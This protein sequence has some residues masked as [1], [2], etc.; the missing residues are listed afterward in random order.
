MLRIDVICHPMHF[1]ALIIVHIDMSSLRN[2][3]QRV[4]VQETHVA[5]CFLDLNLL[6][7]PPHTDKRNQGAHLTPQTRCLPIQHSQMSL[8]TSKS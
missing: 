8:S 6:L 2:G 5:D 7:L 4:I 3:K 1:Y